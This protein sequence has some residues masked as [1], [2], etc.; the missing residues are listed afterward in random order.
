MKSIGY[1]C[2]LILLLAGCNQVLQTPPKEA[3][4][5]HI[6]LLWLNE[7]GNIHDRKQLIDAAGVLQRIPGVIE[8]SVGEPVASDREVVDNSFDVAYIFTFEDVEAMNNYLIHHEHKKAV[9]DLIRPKVAKMLVYDY[10]EA[11]P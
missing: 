4:L 8:I 1:C 2:F 3:K 5:K 9:N 10:F 6:V 11:L 7:P